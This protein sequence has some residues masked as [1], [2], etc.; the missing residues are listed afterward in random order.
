[1]KRLYE[2]SE[3][4]DDLLPTSRLIFLLSAGLLTAEL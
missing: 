1:M 4:K 3:V 2:I